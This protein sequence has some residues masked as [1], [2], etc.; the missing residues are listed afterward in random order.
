M[1]QARISRIALPLRASPLRASPL[2][3]S[4]RSSSTLTI[5]DLSYD[6][7]KNGKPR[8]PPP[9]L[10]LAKYLN[11][12]GNDIALSRLQWMA[13]KDIMQQDMFLL[14]PPGVSRRNLVMA[15]GEMT[16]RDVHVVSISQD[17]TESDL[18]QRR[19]LVN[20][21]A[22]YNN[23]APVT[24]ALNGSLLLLDNVQNAERNILPV[25]NNLLENRELNL[26]DN[27]ML[28]S[29]SRYK[30]LLEGG[31]DVSFLRPTHPDFRIIAT[32][33]PVPP[34]PG[35]TLD[36][37]LRSRFQAM[38]VNSIDA[39]SMYNNLVEIEVSE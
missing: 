22:I 32:G 23:Q 7:N 8:S 3:A 21:S 16:N 18:K 37:P 36:P 39:V 29:H 17:T 15:Y 28:V 25:L 30:N 19:E 24:A 31:A 1:L 6:I 12:T 27:T 34:Y 13:Q 9:A 33:V 26:E 11:T 5:G 4:K 14:G 20:N 2:R 35:N 38:R 10:Y